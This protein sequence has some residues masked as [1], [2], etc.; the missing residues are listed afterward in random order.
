M[1][2]NV[3]TSYL[4]P[5]LLAN[6]RKLTKGQ[7]KAHSRRIKKFKPKFP[8]AAE[9]DY[10]RKLNDY[11]DA[12]YKGANVFI[13]NN[14]SAWLGGERR[15]D[16]IG[17]L[18][19]YITQYLETEYGVVD[20]F[21][22]DFLTGKASQIDVFNLEDWGRFVGTV[23][24]VD[25]AIAQVI[26]P[27]TST[28]IENAIKAWT[29][30]NYV[31]WQTVTDDFINKTTNIVRDN[32]RSNVGLAQTKRDLLK[33][34]PKKNGQPDYN[35]AKLIARD[36]TGS[37]HSQ[38]TKHRMEDAGVHLYDWWTVGDERVRGTPG[39]KN[40][41]ANPRHDIMD[42]KCCDWRN[43]SI[44]SDNGGKTWRDKAGKEEKKHVGMAINCRCS[45]VAVLDELMNAV[46]KV[47]DGDIG[48]D[49]DD[50]YLD[51]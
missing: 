27:T 24:G 22:V 42:G 15:D 14:Y 34:L 13:S 50:F 49:D 19:T 16:D 47:I 23:I 21:I 40:P 20:D 2:K 37:L 32:V 18:C 30:E 5:F 11:I 33:I 41:K 31:L 46:D 10:T 26:T 39:G 9:R 7:R 28:Y 36:Q 44:I 12:L 8:Y 29:D 3:E 38:L 45:G 17:D 43:A 4:F 25:T 48:S 1:N 51:T 35:R 6:R